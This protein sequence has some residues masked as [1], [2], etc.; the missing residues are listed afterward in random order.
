[1]TIWK[2]TEDEGESQGFVLGTG[3]MIKETR[4]GVMALKVVYMLG[5]K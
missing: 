4:E 3:S 2:C 5:G 1:M